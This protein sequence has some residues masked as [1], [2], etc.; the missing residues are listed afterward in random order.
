MSF[1][2]SALRKVAQASSA[3]PRAM[4]TLHTSKPTLGGGH[5]P[6]YVHAKHMYDIQSMPNR[7]LKWA[8]GFAAALTFGFGTPICAVLHQQK[9][10]SG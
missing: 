9:K 7:K 3:A 10:A 5:E 8:V 4:R 1:A 6:D 2:S